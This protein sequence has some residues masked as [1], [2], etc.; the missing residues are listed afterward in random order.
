[1]RKETMGTSQSNRGFSLVELIIVIAIMA[2]LAGALAPAL[3]KY[4]NKSRRSA[5]IQ[6]ADEIRS[7]C[8][9]IASDAD[10]YEKSFG[11]GDEF[12]FYTGGYKPETGTN[13]QKLSAASDHKELASA[14]IEA[15]GTAEITMKYGE[16][17]G[18][19]NKGYGFY[20]YIN[21][22][23]NMVV[24][25]DRTGQEITPSPQGCWKN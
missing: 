17:G 18:K 12:E 13:V 19:A 6:N 15:I 22:E 24:V 7:V 14:L 1:M 23:L 25:K 5:D 8:I 10:V 20:V 9:E 2:I 3:I 4:I 21:P 11:T 16:N